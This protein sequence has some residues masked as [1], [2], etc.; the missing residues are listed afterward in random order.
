MKCITCGQQAELH[1]EDR[2]LQLGLPY[3]VIAQ[4]SPVYVCPGC[5]ARYPALAAP[6]QTLTA[7]AQW[8]VRRPGRLAGAEIR[9]LRNVLAWSQEEL[10]TQLGVAVETISRWENEKKPIGHQ[11][12]LALRLLVLLGSEVAEQLNLP[13]APPQR[14]LVSDGQIV[15][16]AG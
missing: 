2:P 12:E 15:S 8:I 9:F 1:H 11:S 5:G 14:L 16:A 3:T 7:I 10:G 13:A 4:N 6:R